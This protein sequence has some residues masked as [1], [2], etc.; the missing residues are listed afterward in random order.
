MGRRSESPVFSRIGDDK[1]VVLRTNISA[2]NE[3]LVP[4]KISDAVDEYNQRAMRGY[5]LSFSYGLVDYEPERHAE[6]DDLVVAGDE[7]M[8]QRKKRC[9]PFPGA[10]EVKKLWRHEYVRTPVDGT[11]PKR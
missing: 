5:G 3:G 1:F 7:L 2:K 11:E 8:H 6:V 10:A 4:R 9:N